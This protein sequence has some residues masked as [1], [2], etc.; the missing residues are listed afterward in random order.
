M[1]ANPTYPDQEFVGWYLDKNLTIPLD[2]NKAPMESCTIYAKWKT[3]GYHVT[4]DNVP[5]DITGNTARFSDRYKIIDDP[6]N[7]DNKILYY[8][9]E[10]GSNK[11]SSACFIT[12]M[13]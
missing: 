6:D 10:N 13:R 9:L 3:N 12:D 5:K 8:N 7:K 11:S 4:F 2:I 1:P